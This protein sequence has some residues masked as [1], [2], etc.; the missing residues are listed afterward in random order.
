MN[1]IQIASEVVPFA[2]TGGLA[3]VAGALP[4]AIAKEGHTVSVIL[5]YYTSKISPKKF[6]LKP[7]GAIVK[8][9]IE[10]RELEGEVFSCKMAHNVTAFLIKNDHYFG[11]PELYQTAEGDYPDNAERFIFFTKAALQIAAQLSPD[12]IHLHDWQSAM[13]AVYLKSIYR[14]NKAFAKTKV[15]LTIHNLGYQ[16]LFPPTEMGKTGLG[17]EFFTMDKLEFYGKLNFL[18]G[19]IVFADAINTVSKK[20]AEEILTPEYGCGL[21]GVLAVRKNYLH[22]IVNGIDYSEWNPATDTN[23]PA[24]FDA[25]NPSG[26]ALAKAKV[27]EVYKLPVRPDVPLIG[28]ISRLTVQKGFDLLETAMPELMKQDVQFVILGTGEKKYHE[29]LLN[30]AKKYPQKMGVRIAFDN[31]LAHQI[32]AGSDMFLMPSRYEPCG[33]NQLIS[34]KYGT[35]PIVRATGGLDDTIKNNENGFKFTN[36]DAATMIAC[37]KEAL[38]AYKNPAEWKKLMTTAFGDDFSWNASARE[39]IEL[40]RKM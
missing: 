33:L 36:Y 32:E 28:I 31:V 6:K 3:D 40:Y 29:L 16:G 19:G 10:N 24:K 5:P 17:W 8:V 12:V 14:N 1:I 13:A 23:I 11:R 18:K 34:L 21:E 30:V 27:Q 7:T 25:K 9:A 2:K 35:I 4:L 22:G 26:K 37:I 38:A 15:L 20:Y 39:Y